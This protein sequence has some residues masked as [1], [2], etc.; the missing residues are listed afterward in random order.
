MGRPSKK[1]EGQKKGCAKGVAA[2]FAKPPG[3]TGKRPWEETP[4]KKTTP[5]DD[6]PQG[7]EQS[8]QEFLEN[9]SHNGKAHTRHVNINLEGTTS[10]ESIPP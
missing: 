9:T 10:H 6:V 5:S 8:D 4:P 1:A 2:L 7:E 3:G